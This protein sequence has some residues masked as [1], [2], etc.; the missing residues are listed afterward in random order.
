MYDEVSVCSTCF[1]EYSRKDKERAAALEHVQARTRALLAASNAKY[2]KFQG[3]GSLR[4]IHPSKS[5]LIARYEAR[6]QQKQPPKRDT[7]DEMGKYTST[8][9]VSNHNANGTSDDRAMHAMPDTFAM[10]PASVKVAASTVFLGE[11]ESEDERPLEEHSQV[12]EN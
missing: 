12:N 1:E 2:A 7:S 3:K 9:V 11:Q 6:R 5:R 10:E 4:K 8:K